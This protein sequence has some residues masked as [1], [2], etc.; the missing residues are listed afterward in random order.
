M[1]ARIVIPVLMICLRAAAQ[2]PLS[3]NMVDVGGWDMPG[4]TYNDVWGYTSNGNEY[5]ILGSLQKVHFLNVSS[6]TPNLVA[7]FSPGASSIW[8]DFKTYGSY[9]YGVADQGSEGLLIFNLANLPGSVSLVTQTTAF[10]ERAHNIFIDQASGRLY[11][12]GANTQ[13]QGLII[14]SLANPTSPTLLGSVNLQNHGGP[15]SSYVHDVHVYGN[16][17]FCSHGGAQAL[18]I[19][20]VDNPANPV[21]FTHMSGYYQSGYNHSSWLNGTGQYLVF[22]DETHGSSLKIMDLAN[23]T[24]L[25]ITDFFGSDMLQLG[26]S[27]AHNPFIN[28]NY[29]YVSYYHEGVQVFD[30][31]NPAD[32]VKVAYYDTYPSNSN[33]LGYEGCWGVYPFLPSGKILASDIDHGLFVLLMDLQAP[34]PVELISF[35]GKKVENGVRLEWETA[36]ESNND[37]FEIERSL[38]GENF[39]SIAKISGQ[40]TTTQAHTYS[41]L[42]TAPWPMENYYRLKQVDFDGEATF[43]DIVAVDFSNWGDIIISPAIARKGV[44]LTLQFAN[45]APGQWH[46]SVTGLDG[47]MYQ[48]DDIG[49]FEQGGS[50][51]LSTD[52]LPMGI[53]FLIIRNTSGHSRTYR[54]VVAE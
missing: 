35:T 28:G 48:S 32:V 37:H 36:S 18:Y 43:S 4:L 51:S 42:D 9:A 20:R 11:V 44:P 24:N 13:G 14:L 1:L 40:G 41:F 30:I 19:Y 49:D 29:C 46:L 54:F 33:Y 53:Y 10:F 6:P 39:K 34:L 2:P 26:T 15:L 50:W 12:A 38:D 3:M 27:I 16:L 52:M 21:Y 22:A 45:Q 8:R 17:A 25:V 5:A 23:R 7:E 47:H 31:S